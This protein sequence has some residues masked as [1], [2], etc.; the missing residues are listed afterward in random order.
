MEIFDKF[1]K[2]SGLRPEVKFCAYPC[3]T[4]TPKH[5]AEH[6]KRKI[7]HALLTLNFL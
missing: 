7:L 3:K 2:F 4:D 5:L 6:L 1:P